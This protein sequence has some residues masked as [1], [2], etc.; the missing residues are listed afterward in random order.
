MG[1]LSE[2]HFFQREVFRDS[3]GWLLKILDGKKPGGPDCIREVYAT[4]SN[5]GEVRGHH[6][7]HRARE[8]FCVL[9]GDASVLLE[10]PSS[11]DRRLFMLSGETPG[12]LEVPPGVAHAVKASSERPL[13]MVAVADQGHDPGDVV[14]YQVSLEPLEAQE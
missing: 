7:H 2:A 6:Y 4:C 14:P 10:D 11:G 3:R 8:W 13:W 1:K 5:P 9:S 12:V